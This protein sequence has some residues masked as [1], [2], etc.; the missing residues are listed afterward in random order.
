MDLA[1][2]GILPLIII[3]W[4]LFCTFVAIK[5]HGRFDLILWGIVALIPA[6]IFEYIFY[7]RSDQDKVSR[8]QVLL[9]MAMGGVWYVITIILEL[10]ATVL[11]VAGTTNIINLDDLPW[12][13]SLLLISAFAIIVPGFFEETTKLIIA[14]ISSNE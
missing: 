7:F 8:S 13:L 10:L 6:F 2:S 5:E 14:V 12:W 3:V 4:I 1:L 11:I 9:A